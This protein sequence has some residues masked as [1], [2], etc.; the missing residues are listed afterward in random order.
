MELTMI[1]LSAF[2]VYLVFMIVI[3]VVYMKKDKQLRGLL[4]RGQRTE[5][6]GGCIISTGI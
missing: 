2:V 6:L 5:C 1:I 4:P 3:G